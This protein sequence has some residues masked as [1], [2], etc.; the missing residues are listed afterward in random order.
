[1]WPL[2]ALA[3]SGGR[4]PPP[5]PGKRGAVVC[6]GLALPAQS[7]G[8]ALALVASALLVLAVCPGRLRRVGLLAVGGAALA[9]VAG[10]LLDAGGTGGAAVNA[11]VRGLL[12]A[13]VAAGAVWAAIVA[14]ERHAA[15]GTRRRARTA[16]AA[17]AAVAAVV[18]LGAVALS[19]DRLATE[20]REQRDAFVTLG[21]AAADG[22]R[23]R[24][25]SGAGNRHDYWR[26]AVDAWQDRP[27]LGTGAGG[28]GQ[29][30]LLQRRT[31]EDVRQ[32]HS[33]A[34]QQLAELGLPGLALALVVLGAAGW[35]ARR[36][37]AAA[38]TSRLE[39]G[40][41]VAALGTAGAWA[42]HAQVD[43]IHLLPGLTAAALLAAA[44]LLRRDL[45][46]APPAHPRRPPRR[47]ALIAAL[48]VA[49][50]AVAAVSVA[51]QLVA[52]HHRGGAEAAR[53]RAAAGG[54]RA[55]RPR[56]APGSRRRAE[57]VR[58]RRRVRPHGGRR[59]RRGRAARGGGARARRLPPARAARRPRRAPGRD[60]RGP[61]PLPRRP[62]AEPA[63]ARPA[64]RAGRTGGGAMTR[65]PPRSRAATALV[66]A[67]LALPASAGA[68]E[69]GV[70]IDPGDP[71]AKE[72]AI[73][74]EAAR[75]AAAGDGALATGEAPLFGAGVGAVP[76]A[77]AGRR[78]SR[79][80]ASRGRTRPR[81]SHPA[82]RH[83][84]A[85]DAGDGC[86]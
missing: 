84:A 15:D 39:R 28:Y 71:A 32:P 50:V 33:L 62:G 19:A 22:E 46:P 66:A 42:V 85:Q 25:V 70:T 5:A 3:D 80:R 29:P 16:A 75:R 74:L 61:R 17:A 83:P 47:R 54:A 20:V 13:A 21:P 14:A 27:L 53:R 82:A 18:A 65:R 48:L 78:V 67:C 11:A 37:R 77:A 58:A 24:L 12:A 26:I 49:P 64:R 60:R 69:P 68:Q 36:A 81:R 73:P 51:R 10:A 4:R 6:A 57:P 63:R 1:M 79:R 30:Y 40:L 8:A 7:R 23:S 52:Q 59:R 38:R 35:G 31:T 45:A 55:R 44:V 9:A 72:Y 43:W 86:G 76:G 34:L 56:A 2:V 41:L